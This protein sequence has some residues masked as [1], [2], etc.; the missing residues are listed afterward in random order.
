MS[1]LSEI[2]INSQDLD[3]SILEKRFLVFNMLALA[4]RFSTSPYFG[5]I[6]AV[7][8]GNEFAEKAK[9]LYGESLRTIQNPTL[10][11]LQGCTLLAWYLYLSGPNSQGW[12][13]IGTCSRLAY[14]LGIDKVDLKGQNKTKIRAELTWSQ[15]EELRRVWWS[16]WELDTFASAISCRSHT[17]DRAKMAVMLP[18][19]DENWFNDSPLE[20]VVINPD[21]LHAWYSL[22]D[23]PNQDE[24]AWFLL[25]NYLLLIAH[26]LSQEQAPDPEDIQNIEKAVT[27]YVLL[28]PAEFHLDSDL[29]PISFNSS[30]YARSNWIVCTNIMIQGYLCL[31]IGSYMSQLTANTGAGR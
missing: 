22:R 2:D 29:N 15:R 26:D 30:N 13:M 17:I 21:P 4:A 28:L 27:C 9:F 7:D 23:S 10:G 5:A 11:Y 18:V 8:R 3:Q 1:E 14:D 16:I 6:P 31:Q 20:S 24:R 19:S 25:I 12:L